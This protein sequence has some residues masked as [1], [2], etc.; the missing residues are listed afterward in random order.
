M[1]TSA[2][3][4][5]MAP[6]TPGGSKLRQTRKAIDDMILSPRS[7]QFKKDR[8]RIEKDCLEMINGEFAPYPPYK[9]WQD[10][11]PEVLDVGLKDDLGDYDSDED[12]DF[13]GGAHDDGLSD[14]DEGDVHGSDMEE[15]SE[16]EEKF[17]AGFWASFA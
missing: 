15:M 6:Q 1:P 8:R 12:D 7:N 4:E 14:G 17:V 2:T 5:D 3:I 13:I 10:C 9:A 11:F 16:D